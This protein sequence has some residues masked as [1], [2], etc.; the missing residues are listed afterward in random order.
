MSD[1]ARSPLSGCAILIAA[2]CMLL[3][4]IG[5]SAWVPFRQA[6]AMEKFTAPEASPV[7]VAPVDPTQAAELDTRLRNFQ[8]ALAVE[9]EEAEATFTA[10]DLN[11]II[12]HYPQLEELRGTFHVQGI[13]DGRIIVDICYQLNGRPRLAKE[14]EDALITADPRF[15]IGTMQVTPFLSKRELSLRVESLEVPGAEVDEGFMGHFSTLRILERFLEDPT[16]GSAMARLTSAQVREDRLVLSRTPGQPIPDVVTDEEFQ[17]SG[18]KV[19]LFIGGAMLL[20]LLVAGTLL[21]L[22]YRTQL[23]KLQE[24]E[25]TKVDSDN[26]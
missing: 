18:S 24:E 14:G 26:V 11:R 12:A 13:R 20:F 21:Y 9:G 22:G 25:R 15:L 19:A 7:P 16:I 10:D 1:S 2:V 5:F 3:F 4:L 8:Q 17:K 23:K 6:A